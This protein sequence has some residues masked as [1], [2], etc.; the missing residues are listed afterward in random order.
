MKT[1]CKPNGLISLALISAIGLVVLFGSGAPAWA[2]IEDILYEKGTITKE[3]WLK[4]KADKEKTQAMPSG[5]GMAPASQGPRPPTPPVGGGNTE[6]AKT[7]DYLKGVDVGITVY[8][9]FTGAT[10]T[11]FTGDPTKG[12]SNAT[13]NNNKGLASG[14]HFT[15]TYLNVRKY[16]DNGD[17]IR[18]TLDQMV[19]DV[20]GNSCPNANTSGGNCHEAAPFGLSGFAG[21]GRNNTFLKYVYYD[22]LFVPGLQMRFGMHQT[23]WIEYEE[24]RWTYRWLFPTMVDQQNLQTSA[25][26]GVSLLGKVLDNR[27]EYHVAFQEGEGYQNTPDG[28]G[29][30]I[31][32]RV[33]VEPLD[34][35]IL[36]AFGH[37]ERERN[38]IE[39]FNPQRLLGNIEFY[40]PTSDRFKLNAQMVWGDDGA[41]IGKS[42]SKAINVPGTYNTS[43]DTAPVTYGGINGPTT[44]IPRFHQARGY[45]IWAWYRI[46]GF[47]KVRLHGRYYFMKPNKDTVAGD[48]QSYYAG[49]SYDYSK[50][51]SF[52]V[53][54][55]VL[56]ETVLGSLTP[57]QALPGLSNFGSLTGNPCTS[58][59]QYVNYNNQIVGLRALIQF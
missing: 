41:D 28:R 58:C 14:F 40:D 30:A 17:H 26:L 37:N 38:G 54:Y 9:D 24:H 3:E 7:T 57:A 8:A 12:V 49:I 25:D 11:S 55:T 1:Q 5:T 36:S 10:G 21:T 35:I 47:E 33:S 46:P 56:Q 31:L 20:G 22:H 16:F 4:I 53:D 51:L 13:A 50:N 43:T 29:Y 15:R 2:D 45:E 44:S 48:I 19:N 52:S 39:G 32:G 42:F 23:P 34:G 59:G 18:L 27:L 6:K